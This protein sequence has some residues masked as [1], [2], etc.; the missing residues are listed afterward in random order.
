MVTMRK[1]FVGLLIIIA[2]V[3][4]GCS[5]KKEIAAA[6]YQIRDTEFVR[7]DM[8]GM[9]TLRVWAKGAKKNDALEQAQKK[10]VYEVTFSGIPSGQAGH[11]SYPVI[12]NPSAKSRHEAYFNKFFSDGGTYKKFV[13]LSPKKEAEEYQGQGSVTVKALV[14][15]DRIKL[16]QRFQKDK[17]IE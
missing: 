12:D 13:K 17:I 6:S 1:L 16:K 14:D 3:T 5:P 7:D 8:D 11:N 9:M 10:A 15:V 4:A 2:I